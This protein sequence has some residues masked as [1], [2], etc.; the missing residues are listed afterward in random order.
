MPTKRNGKS[1]QIGIYI[2]HEWKAAFES[3]G[4]VRGVGYQT[5]MKEILGE[6]LGAAGMTPPDGEVLRRAAKVERTVPDRRIYPVG[7]TVYFIQAGEGGPIKIGF[8]LNVKARMAGLQ[9][10]R[11][12]KLKLLLTLP[13]TKVDEARLHDKFGRFRIQGEWF[14]PDPAV[15]KSIEV[16]RAWKDKKGVT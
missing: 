2:P 6:W 12:E 11:T 13:G 4:K 15:L 1:H 8:S 14:K 5:F 16:L 9:T 3:W 10:G 7:P